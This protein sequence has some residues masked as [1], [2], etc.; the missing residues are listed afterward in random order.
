MNRI[1]Q[2]VE[3]GESDSVNLD[4]YYTP[5]DLAEYVV[6]KTREIVGED[7]IIEFVEPS[8]GGGVFLEYLNKP[9]LA[10][11]IEP[12][13]ESIMKQDFLELNLEYKKGRCVIGNPPYGT[14]NTLAVRFFKK[15]IEI[16]DYIAFILPSSQYEN[17]NQ[18]YEFDLIHSEL[19]S[20]EGFKGLDKRVNLAFNIYKRNSQGYN[21]KPN[22]KLKNVLIKEARKGVKH[23]VT[24]DY[25]IGICSFGWSVG[26][27]TDFVGQYANEFYLYVSDSYKE[28]V[29]ELIASTDWRK[30]IKT[31]TST[32]K[33]NQWQVYKYIK[34][35]IPEID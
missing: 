19:V 15:S 7:N 22:Y 26:K 16:G 24:E 9:Y 28:Q 20:N 8:A 32:E 29:R 31:M 17:T 18:M 1:N 14:R 23:N 33:I 4:K 10:Y 13:N 5:K 27:E 6:K 25:E 34:E 35:Q 2:I 30:E 12:D 11:D 3:S 21:S